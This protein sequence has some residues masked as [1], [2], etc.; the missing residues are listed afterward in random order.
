MPPQGPDQSSQEVPVAAPDISEQQPQIDA[1][2]PLA[3]AEEL[4]ANSL[5]QP[6]LRTDLPS[7]H[8]GRVPQ[9]YKTPTEGPLT[10]EDDQLLKD[11]YGTEDITHG[12][13]ER[14]ILAHPESRQNL[15][16]WAALIETE[17]ALES[18]LAKVQAALYANE[19]EGISL[20]TDLETVEQKIAAE[21]RVPAEEVRAAYD[22][23]VAEAAA[24]APE[25][26]T[27]DDGMPILTRG[28]VPAVPDQAVPVQDESS[29]S[30]VRL[31][32]A[33]EPETPAVPQA[34]AQPLEAPAIS[35]V[36]DQLDLHTELQAA[37][38]VPAP[39]PVAEELQPESPQ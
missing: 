11:V 9:E 38:T 32:Q 21:P 18:I 31:A 17:K 35:T 2:T 22:K 24:T 33:N 27:V 16:Q 20:S 1:E 3:E 23:Q 5:P 30:F 6:S 37:D 15:E 19:E 14:K 26:T 8:A 25:P 10:V 34:P 28:Q 13:E 7:P 36:E 4:V 29:N 12:P 39:A